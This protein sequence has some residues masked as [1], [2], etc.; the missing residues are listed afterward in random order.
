M[1]GDVEEGLGMIEPRGDE[2]RPASI[3]V[4]ASPRIAVTP[5]K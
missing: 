4:M 3:N 5:V 2:A 1:V